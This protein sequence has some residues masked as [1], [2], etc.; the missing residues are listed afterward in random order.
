METADFRLRGRSSSILQQQVFPKETEMTW[1]S[2]RLQMLENLKP[3]VSLLMM[4]VA[5][6]VA[7]SM[8]SLVLLPSQRLCAEDETADRVLFFQ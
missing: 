3:M 1:A 7:I 8:T 5:A 2:E 6:W 4:P